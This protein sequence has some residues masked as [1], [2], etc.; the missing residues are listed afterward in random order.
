[1]KQ[2]AAEELTVVPNTQN[3]KWSTIGKRLKRDKWL[4]VLLAPGLLYF[5]LFKYVPMWGIMLAFKN[6]QPFL[7]FFK[8]DWVGLDH[9]TMFFQNI[10]FGMLLRN[11]LVLSLYSLVFSFPAPILLALLLNEVRL[12]WY[13]RSIQ[14]LV[15]VPHFIS[16]VIVASLTYILLTTEGGTVNEFIFQLTGQKISFLTDPE[17]FRPLIIIQTIWKECGWGTVI[18]LA[19]LAGVD[20]EQYEAAIMD[21]ANRWKQ[22]WHIT[23][24]SIRSTI[25]ILLILRM[26]NIMDNGFEQIYLMMNALN[27]EV[28]EVFDTYVYTVGITQGAFSYSTAVGLFKSVI[29]VTLVL[30]SNWLAKRFGESGLY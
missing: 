6:Y 16:M 5:I 27:R 22:T 10:E 20:V 4:Y 14:T 8:S 26:G 21:G 28:A 9:F 19:A 11:T 7:G 3:S 12:S 25:V 13:K 29:G 30:G 24:P 1:M 17:W 15:Y 18:F 2:A 23:L